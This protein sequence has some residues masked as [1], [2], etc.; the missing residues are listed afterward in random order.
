MKFLS[1]ILK[2]FSVTLYALV[3]TILIHKEEI[4]EKLINT[5]LSNPPKY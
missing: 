4:S 5:F 2:L 1:L 3:K